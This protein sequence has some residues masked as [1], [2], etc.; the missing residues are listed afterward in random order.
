MLDRIM[1]NIIKMIG[2]IILLAEGMFPNPAKSP[3]TFKT[4]LGAL[5][6]AQEIVDYLNLL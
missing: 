4:N 1:I 5:L 3:L 6:C 2:K